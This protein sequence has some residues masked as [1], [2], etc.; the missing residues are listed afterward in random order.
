MQPLRPQAAVNDQLE[1]ALQAANCGLGRT[2]DM[3]S[4]ALKWVITPSSR[5]QDSSRKRGSSAASVRHAHPLARHPGIDL[6]V[7]RNR[8]G[9]HAPRGSRPLPAESSCQG[10]PNHRSQAQVDHRIGFPAKDAR[11]QQNARLQDRPRAPQ[12]PLRSRSPPTTG[13]RGASN[14]AHASTSWP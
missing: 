6:Q 12:P 8:S 7:D 5:R 1:R 2:D 4:G 10:L 13:A 14:G 9:R 3:V 11:H